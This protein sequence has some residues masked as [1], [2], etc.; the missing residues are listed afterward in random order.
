MIALGRQQVAAAGDLLVPPRPVLVVDDGVVQHHQ[1]LACFQE[2]AQVAA[3]GFAVHIRHVVEHQ[4][5]GALAHVGM[6]GAGVGIDVDFEIAI[7]LE[8]RVEGNVVGMAA[9]HQLD[10][11]GRCIG[12]QHARGASSRRRF[13]YTIPI[14]PPLPAM[15]IRATIETHAHSLRLPAALLE[16]GGDGAGSGGDQPDLLAARPADLP[17]HHRFLRHPLPR[18]HERAVPARRQRAAGGGGGRR[19]RFARRQEFSGLLRQPDHAAGGRA[20][21]RRRHPPLAGTA[22]HAV[23]RPAQRRD[24][25]QT[26]EGPDRCGEVHLDGG[27]P[28]VHDADR[29]GV[30]DG[31]RVARA[32]VRRAGVPAHGAAAR[33][34][35]LGAEP[36]DQGSAE[37]HRARD[38]GAGRAPPR[39][40]CAI[41]NW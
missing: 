1:A 23:R 29:P 18:V 32:L 8:N 7:A 40:R 27:E 22:L 26:A 2:L 12:R 34:A 4:Y 33:R 28:G 14:L 41:S 11:Y 20:H 16:T 31:L 10:A 36:Q 30:R 9:G 3:F 25:G 24:A 13:S 19:V 15:T 35:E 5:V 6:K 21:L 17:P 38:H 37:A 39:N